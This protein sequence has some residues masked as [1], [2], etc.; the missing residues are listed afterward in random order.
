MRGNFF[1]YWNP[2][3][4]GL[5]FGTKV[6]PHWDFKKRVPWTALPWKDVRPFR[7]TPQGTLQ[8]QG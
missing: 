2:Q 3:Y 4:Q 7:I 6:Q 8:P 1:R 5:V